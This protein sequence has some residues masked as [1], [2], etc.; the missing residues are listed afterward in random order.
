MDFS[1]DQAIVCEGIAGG[2]DMLLTS[3]VNTID[4][5][6]LNKWLVDSGYRDNQFIHSPDFGLTELVGQSKAELAH[7]VAI[8]MCLSYSERDPFDEH[9]SLLQFAD[10]LRSSFPNFR[11]VIRH[12]ELRSNKASERW[13]QARE[14][15]EKDEW[16]EIRNLEP[17]RILR[18]KQAAL[19]AGFGQER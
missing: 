7:V 2:A 16:R 14:N 12:E 10:G 19:E 8:T 4:H 18:T 9:L 13:N 11:S 6:R 3:N 1:Q 5:V 17:Q 15:L